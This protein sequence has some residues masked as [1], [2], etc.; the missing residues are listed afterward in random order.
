MPG[1]YC[2]DM[3][4]STHICSWLPIF[5]TATLLSSRPVH[6]FIPT[7]STIKDKSQ[8]SSR[9][10]VNGAS[11][12]KRHRHSWCNWRRLGKDFKPGNTKKNGGNEKTRN[13]SHIQRNIRNFG[14][15]PQGA[16]NSF[17]IIHARSLWKRKIP[18]LRKH[19]H[20]IGSCSYSLFILQNS[21]TTE[22]LLVSFWW[23]ISSL[24][25]SVFLFYFL[26]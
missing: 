8:K 26:T 2:K 6:Q 1:S 18:G 20:P 22:S 5:C 25:F 17:T 21:D 24:S 9:P 7:C 3:I 19:N 13:P 11:L 14:C 12:S 15:S 23:V 16:L 10:S 4:P